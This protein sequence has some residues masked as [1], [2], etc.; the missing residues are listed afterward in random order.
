M[1]FG[2]E[3]RADPHTHFRAQ[4]GYHGP[5]DHS[6]GLTDAEI[7]ERI[8]EERWGEFLTWMRGQT[9]GACPHGCALAYRHDVENFMRGGRIR[10]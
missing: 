4:P 5:H 3:K 9:I 2:N 10:D 6:V 7:K 8:G 1:S